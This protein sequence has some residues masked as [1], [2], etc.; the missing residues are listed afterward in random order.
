MSIATNTTTV[1]HFSAG[2]VTP[3]VFVVG[4]DGT[5]AKFPGVIQG[6]RDG[7]VF[8]VNE[9]A[10]EPVKDNDNAIPFATA[11]ITRVDMSTV[12]GVY[13]EDY[14]DDAETFDADNST[15][16]IGWECANA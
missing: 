14:D 6:F 1:N 3:T 8:I 13:A 10:G 4:T 5:K 9:V 12:A 2:D 15:L 7:F 16:A 11:H